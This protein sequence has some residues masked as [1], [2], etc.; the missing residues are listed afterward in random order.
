MQPSGFKSSEF[1]LLAATTA[2]AGLIYITSN[3]F[4]WKMDADT[5]NIILAAVGGNV[6][7]AGG[8]SWIKAIIARVAKEQ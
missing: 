3:A 2:L 8:R 6:V 1:A 7:Y 5:M 4:G